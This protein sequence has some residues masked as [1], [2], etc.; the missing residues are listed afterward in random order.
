MPTKEQSPR[1]RLADRLKALGYQC[2][3]V[4]SGSKIRIHWGQS[5]D[6]KKQPSLPHFREERE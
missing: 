3:L 4:Q 2:R 1:W 5:S 6:Q